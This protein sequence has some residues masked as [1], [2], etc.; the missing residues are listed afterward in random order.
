M[1]VQHS[2]TRP[3]KGGIWIEGLTEKWIFYLRS[4]VYLSRGE[5]L[6]RTPNVLHLSQ[7]RVKFFV[8]VLTLNGD[9]R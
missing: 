1:D 5:F 3:G 6:A 4:F 9:E 8:Q 7:V 2:G